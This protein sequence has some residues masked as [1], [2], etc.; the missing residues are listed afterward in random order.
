MQPI[1]EMDLAHVEAR[2]RRADAAN[3][4]RIHAVRR[5]ARSGSGHPVPVALG[6][7]LRAAAVLRDLAVF[8]DPDLITA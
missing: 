6:A 1:I 5:A 2:E 8:L 7:R 3:H 4:A